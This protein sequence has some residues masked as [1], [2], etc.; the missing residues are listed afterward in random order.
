M[1]LDG[2]GRPLYVNAGSWWADRP[3]LMEGLLRP[4]PATSPPPPPPPSGAAAEPQRLCLVHGFQRLQDVKAGL[5]RR[6]QQQQVWPCCRSIIWQQ[7]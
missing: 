4:L 1:Q 3:E 5:Q 2:R 7:R 6:R